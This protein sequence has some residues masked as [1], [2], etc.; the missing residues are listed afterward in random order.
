MERFSNFTNN[1][2]LIEAYKND[3]LFHSV[4]TAHEMKTS[5]YVE[6]LEDAVIALIEKANTA[7]DLSVKYV[8]R[9]GQ[10]E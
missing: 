5:S 1:Q 10:I 8:R 4:V 3:S 2:R 7:H 6:M 9:Y